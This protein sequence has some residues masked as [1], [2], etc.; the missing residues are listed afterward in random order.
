MSL[1]LPFKDTVWDIHSITHLWPCSP[2]SL[3]PL[4]FTL[5]NKSGIWTL[6][7]VK[8]YPFITTLYVYVPIYLNSV[9]DEDIEI[10]S[11]LMKQD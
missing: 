8:K 2:L 6:R 9:H 1:N 4:F 3:W 7:G 11:A 10:Q 5:E